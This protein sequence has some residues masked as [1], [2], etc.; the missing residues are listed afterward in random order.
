MRHVDVVELTPAAIALRLADVAAH[1]VG[2]NRR[3]EILH[4]GHHVEPLLSDFP[5][6]LQRQQQVV[7]QRLDPLV[8]VAFV[9]VAKILDLLERQQRLAHL[10][11]AREQWL[12]ALRHPGEVRLDRV[13][14]R[15]ERLDQIA[16]EIV[17]NRHRVDHDLAALRP[18][19]PFLRRA[20]GDK[21]RAFHQRRQ[22]V[23][24]PRDG[25]LGKDN[26]QTPGLD[27]DVDRRADRRP[28]HPLAIDAKRAHAADHERREP[29][30]FE[31]VPTRHG[32]QMP[33]HLAR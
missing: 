3:T 19:G 24:L 32:I 16:A 26:Q 7:D 12:F 5:L 33:L 14:H 29:V 9:G 2:Q 17:P 6:I 4:A 18:F 13:E 25:P 20:A 21:R 30:L 23:V 10:P 22:L 11:D 28:V 8:Q 31:Q 27:Q 15:R 1:H